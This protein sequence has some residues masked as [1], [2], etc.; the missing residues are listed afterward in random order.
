MRKT[1]EDTETDRPS[2][3][4]KEYGGGDEEEEAF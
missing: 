3:L 1:L 4:E 2:G